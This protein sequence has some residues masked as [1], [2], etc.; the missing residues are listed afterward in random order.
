MFFFV[1]FLILNFFLKQF[2][3]LNKL[4]QLIKPKIPKNPRKNQKTKKP[5]KPKKN[6]KNKKTKKKPQKPQKPQK[7]PK[8]PKKKT[9]KPKNHWA[10]F[11]NRVFSNHETGGPGGGPRGQAGRRG[12]PDGRIRGAARPPEGLRDGEEGSGHPAHP[13]V[14]QQPGGGGGRLQPTTGGSHP[15]EVQGRD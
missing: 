9:K 13:G 1:F 14:L 4:K 2:F 5:K 12:R 7:N 3:S 10:G 8:K 15:G 11:F 6:K